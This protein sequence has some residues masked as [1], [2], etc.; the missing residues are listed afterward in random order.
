MRADRNCYVFEI[1]LES[2]RK[3]YRSADFDPDFDVAFRFFDYVT[4]FIRNARADRKST[5]VG[6]GYHTVVIHRARCTS[7]FQFVNNCRF[8][9]VIGITLQYGRINVRHQHSRIRRKAHFQ[10]V[11]SQQNLHLRFQRVKFI[12]VCNQSLIR[13]FQSV[14]LIPRG[15]HLSFV[16]QRKLL[17]RRQRINRS[18]NVTDF[19]GCFLPAA[20]A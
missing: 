7:V 13:V 5:A 9:R 2:F 18:N 19:F 1:F 3:R 15:L 12:K 16:R 10:P 6:Y 4:A 8:D 14:V 20:C 11:D 17:H